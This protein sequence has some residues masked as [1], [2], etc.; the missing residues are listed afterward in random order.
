MVLLSGRVRGWRGCHPLHFA[1]QESGGREAGGG[2]RAPKAAAKR[3][4][5]RRRPAQAVAHSPALPLVIAL[6]SGLLLR[7][8]RTEFGDWPG[9]AGRVRPSGPRTTFQGLSRARRAAGLPVKAAARVKPAVGAGRRPLFR[10]KA[11]VSGA[12][13][14]VPSRAHFY[15]AVRPWISTSSPQVWP[16][17]SGSRIPA[18]RADRQVRSALRLR[19]SRAA[20]RRRRDDIIWRTRGRR[21]TLAGRGHPCTIVGIRRG[22]PG[23]GNPRPA[24]RRC[25]SQGPARGPE[26][27]VLWV[28]TS[29]LHEHSGYGR[30]G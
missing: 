27:P 23:Q 18:K 1:L 15:G 3:L 26:G 11:S 21:Q 7:T 9:R 16:R 14:P 19:S 29:R 8:A 10:S 4:P 2:A 12:D 17:R 30:C 28:T 5:L 24:G 22:R 20:A 6:L 13:L 25:S